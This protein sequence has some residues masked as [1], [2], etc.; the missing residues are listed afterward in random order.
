MIRRQLNTSLLA[1]LVLLLFVSATCQAQSQTLLTRHTR[2]VIFN[3]QAQLTGRLPAEKTMRIEIVLPLRNRPELEKF[4]HTVYDRN[5]PSYRHFLTVEQFTERFGPT[6][7]DYDSVLAFAKAN[8]LAVASTSRNRMNIGVTGTVAN[9]EKTFHVTMGVYQHPSEHRTFYAPDREPVVDLPFPLWHVA[10]LDNYSIPRPLSVKR[11]DA[12]VQPNASVGSG[13]GPGASFLGS[14]MRAAYYGRTDLDGSGQSVGIFSFRGTDLSDLLE[15]YNNVGQSLNTQINIVS[16]DGAPTTCYASNGCDDTEPTIDMTQA[17]GMAPN[18]SSLVMYVGYHDVD[19]F[20]AMATAQ[21][22]DLQLSISW[23]WSP[24]DPGADDPY[25]QEFAAQGQSVFAAAG[26]SGAWSS[27]LLTY[28]AED[29]YVTSVGGTDLYTQY[30]GGPWAAETAWADTGG[31]IS[32]NQL[33]MPFWQIGVLTSGCNNCSEVYRNGPDVAANANFSFYVCSNQ[34]GCT[35]NSYGGT[36]F[37]APMWAGLLALANQEAAATGNLPV[38]FVNP[39]LYWAGFNSFYGNYFYD[40]TSG[41]NNV[42]S[43]NPGF[44]LVTGWGS[45]TPNMPYF[46]AA[47]PGF[48]LTASPNSVRVN[49]GGGSATTTINATTRGGFN[50]FINLSVAGTPQGVSVSLSSPYVTGATNSTMTFTV[51]PTTAPGTYTITVTGTSHPFVETTKVTLTVVAPGFNVIARPGTITVS[52]GTSGS[53]FIHT[54]VL[55]GFNAPITLSVSGQGS[56]NTVT[57]SPNP[58]PKPG[59]GVSTM[60]VKVSPTATLGSH[61]MTLTARGGG[62]TRTI[63]M[64]LYVQP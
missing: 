9:I 59:A 36:S 6:R 51:A 3:G 13:S 47:D 44:D 38:G 30:A 2:E 39:A 33:P 16:A 37:A 5:S 15:Y 27:S 60:T 61:P 50:T 63:S 8:G 26:D 46:L 11:A 41:A 40:T 20:N 19:I 34:N 31:G 35:A 24:A 4:L 1:I 62:K 23:A 7:K 55:G 48:S 52:R 21:P 58:V 49:Q 64:T 56:G 12:D 25:F 42:Y 57:F 28:P 22:L 43:A 29:P 32:P 14:D 54:T 17:L 53:S 10:G 45:P 18:L